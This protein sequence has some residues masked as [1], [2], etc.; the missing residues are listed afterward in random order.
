MQAASLQ[1]STVDCN[2]ER[3]WGKFV[4]VCT[5]E[6]LE[7][8]PAM[9]TTVQ[10]YLAAM[11]EEGTTTTTEELDGRHGDNEDLPASLGSKEQI[12]P[13]EMKIGCRVLRQDH[14][15]QRTLP[16]LY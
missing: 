12:R 5:R 1:K 10:L 15:Q 4:Q 3:H 9:A 6:K 13:F 7:W 2:Y 11:K 16:E 8:L 14:H